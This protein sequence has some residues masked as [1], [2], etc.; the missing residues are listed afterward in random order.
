MSFLLLPMRIQVRFLHIV[1]ACSVSRLYEQK[2][3][4]HEHIKGVYEKLLAFYFLVL[5]I[6]KINRHFITLSVYPWCF[7]GNL[8]LYSCG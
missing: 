2:T 6:G 7:N 3:Y 5:Y 4:I 1:A 8:N